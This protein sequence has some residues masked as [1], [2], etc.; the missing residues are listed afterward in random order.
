M[1]GRRRP[2]RTLVASPRLRHPAPPQ[3]FLATFA[4]TVAVLVALSLPRPGTLR[5]S[6]DFTLAGRSLGPAAVA[7]VILGTLVGGAS[8]VGTV[9]LAYE[10]GLNAWL[11]TLGSGLACAVLGAFFA[12]PLRKAGVVTVSEWIG[13]HFGPRAALASSSFAA[14]G[15]FIHLVAQLLAA[16]AV[17]RAAFPIER[18]PALLLASALVFVAAAAGGLSGSSSLGRAKFILLAIMLLAGVAIAWRKTSPVTVAASLPQGDW[19][20][21]FAQGLPKGASDLG[22]MIIGVLSTQT[23]LQAVFAARDARAARRGALL[24]AALIPPIGLLA[25]GIGLFLRA[26]RPDLAANTARALPS[27]LDQAFPSPVAGLFSAGLLII[28]VATAAGLALGVTTNVHNDLLR[29]RLRRVPDVLALRACAAVVVLAAATIVFFSR[30]TTILAWSFLSMGMRGAAVFPALLAATFAP[31]LAGSPAV[32]AAL[33]LAPPAY[34]AVAI[35]V[36]R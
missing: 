36:L 10:R 15:M 19:D 27:F 7:W 4:L 28:I 13:Q 6:R 25:V 26:T 5:T 14:L 8:T 21:L 2:A 33:W 34:L 35:F 30:E 23:Y 17:L 11:F 29:P 18:T 24:A 22:A 31:R 16:T 3:V 12:L 32:R 1:L 9:Q 20:N